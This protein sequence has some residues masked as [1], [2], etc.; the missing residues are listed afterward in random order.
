[1]KGVLTQGT[2]RRHPLAGGRP[3]AGKTGTQADN[4]NAWFVGFTPEITTAVWVGDPNGYTPMRDVPEFD[5]GRVQ[6]G[7]Y[8]AEI[9][10][11]YMDAALEGLPHSDWEAP[12]L[13]ARPPARLYLPGN[14]C[15]YRS[16]TSGGGVVGT[17]P[18]RRGPNGFRRPEQTPPGQPPVLPEAPPPTT[19]A[20]P[21][22]SPT[23]P[24]APTTAAPPAA[25]PAAP[26][27]PA[28]P[29]RPAAGTPITSPV[30]TRRVVIDS[31]TTVPPD[32]L[33]PRAPIP[34]A[35]AGASV[36]SC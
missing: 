26:A 21:A 35:P 16:V 25:G 12:P 13:P 10:K 3:G 24:P 15:L 22:A 19:V 11:R 28:A 5:V 20:P 29:S 2:A 31:G 27:A 34:S 14:E 8:P 36:T 4:T 32:V 17:V 23:A 7:L 18:G 33:D 1:M 9:W 6:G 30:V